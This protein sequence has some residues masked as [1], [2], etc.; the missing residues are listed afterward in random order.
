MQ[1]SRNRR[2]G[3][4]SQDYARALLGK[5]CFL[6]EP[7]GIADD[8]GID[9]FCTLFREEEKKY[10]W[11][12]VPD[13]NFCIQIKSRSDQSRLDLAKQVSTLKILTL[14]YFLGIMD[15]AQQVLEIYS[16]HYLT[17]FFSLKGADGIKKLK[18]ETCASENISGVDYSFFDDSPSREFVIRFPLVTTIR[19]QIDHDRI[20]QIAEDLQLSSLAMS[21]NIASAILAEHMFI[22]HNG[23]G[24]LLNAGRGSLPFFEENLFKR[25]A[26]A[27]FNLQIANDVAENKTQVLERFATMEKVYRD[28]EEYYGKDSRFANLVP[29]FYH[30]A[31]NAMVS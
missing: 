1:Q 10:D 23:Q 11:G 18:V 29:R 31:K 25:L 20:R 19:E 9:F 26:I 15:K 3:Y 21:Q 8:V 6:A 5:V 4:R 2:E 27:F 22:S 30:A 13:I 16:G 14:P 17:P 28:L 12:L 7:N 24:M